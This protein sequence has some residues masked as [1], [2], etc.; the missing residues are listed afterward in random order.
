MGT[1][2]EDALATPCASQC[3]GQRRV[4]RRHRKRVQPLTLNFY[5]SGSGAVSFV[6]CGRD[7]RGSRVWRARETKGMKGASGTAGTAGTAGAAVAAGTA[8]KEGA[9]GTGRPAEEPGGRGTCE[10][11]PMEGVEGC[12]MPGAMRPMRGARLRS[13]FGGKRLRPGAG[14]LVEE[15]EAE[16]QLRAVLCFGNGCGGDGG[17]RPLPG[18]Q[19][20]SRRLCEGLEASRAAAAQREAQ[21]LKRLALPPAVNLQRKMAVLSMGSSP[22]KE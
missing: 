11:E 16:A 8:G 3:S 10:G 1:H 12:A 17:G 18:M 6:F 2:F 20:A 7:M 13:P 5:P 9:E 4:R 14:V 15:E 22:M 19:R 21:L